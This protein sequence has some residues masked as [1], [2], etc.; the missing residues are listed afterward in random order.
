MIGA[1]RAFLVSVKV[2]QRSKPLR[3]AEG[4]KIQ[5]REPIVPTH[6]NFDVSPDHPLWAFFRDGNKTENVLREKDELASDSRAWTVAE[7]RL[8]SFDDLHKL[9]YLNLRER[10]VLSTEGDVATEIYNGDISQYVKLDDNH[11]LTQKRIKVVL[12]E[13]QLAYERAQL[14]PQDEYLAEFKDRYVSADDSQIAE[15]NEKLVRLQYAM[16]G[17]EPDLA[18]YDLAEDI[19]IKFVQGLS[20]V[21]DLKLSRYLQQNPDALALPLN[22][23]MEELPFLVRDTEVAV[24]EVQALRESGESRKLDNIEVFGFLRSAIEAVRSEMPEVEEEAGN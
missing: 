1:R 10:N 2:A 5:L 4:A 3:F 16:F 11:L 24:S 15:M 13:R 22:G 18:E 19:N 9:W 20:Y 8:K 6:K 7:L 23:V 14:L 12:L 21:A 17:I